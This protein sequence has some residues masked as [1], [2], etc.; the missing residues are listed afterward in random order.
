MVIAVLGQSISHVIEEYD[1][2]KWEDEQRTSRLR[3]QMFGL[4]L[5]LFFWFTCVVIAF[6]R[7]RNRQVLEDMSKT[8]DLSSE[9]VGTLI[10][11][12]VNTLQSLA[13][14]TNGR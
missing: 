7:R 6:F 9:L 1:E 14:G 8:Q 11:D 5:V 2:N 3:Q 12:K 13:D 10:S 4:V